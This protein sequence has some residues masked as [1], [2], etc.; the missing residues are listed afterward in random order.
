[1]DEGLSS[2]S[3]AR[4]DEGA[5]DE[6]GSDGDEGATRAVL[7]VLRWV[8]VNDDSD[9]A[10]FVGE[11]VNAVEGRNDLKRK[12]NNVSEC[13]AQGKLISGTYKVSTA[14]GNL[15]NCEEGRAL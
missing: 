14:V 15:L 9:R 2:L 10:V 13:R 1:M 5:L 4:R 3:A 11:S 12:S 7:G 8:S 6:V